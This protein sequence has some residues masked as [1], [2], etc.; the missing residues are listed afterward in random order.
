MSPNVAGALLMMASMA[1]FTIN[2]AFIKVAGAQMP[3]M[4]ILF[5]RG[6]LTTAL[7]LALA[8]ALGQFQ[9]RMARR[10][11]ILVGLRTLSE[12]G[13]AIFF[14]SALMNM[15]IANVTAILQVLPLSVSLGAALF[16]SEPLGWRRLL[17]IAV[18]FAGMLLIVRPGADG[19]SIWAVYALCAVVCITMRDLVTR[20]LSKDVP[21]MTVTLAAS[22]GVVAFAAVA[23]AAVEWQPV[24]LD[25]AALIAGAGVFV[26][27]GY[28]FSV[29]VMR[30][31]DI[32]FIA[33]FRY[34]S[35]IWALVIGFVIFGEWPDAMTFVGAAIVVGTGLFTLYRERL[36][37]RRA[38]D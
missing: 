28:Y 30:V 22:V 15:P 37:L 16:L 9:F 31:G 3:L 1:A 12:I 8:V 13:A 14:L 24:T 27:G 36:A 4:Q 23:S 19:F 29:R 5:L 17:A 34:T 10:D 18:G 35:L 11:W 26:L 25:L 7:I 2:D 38:K 32:G 21:S 33:P 20:R 6:I